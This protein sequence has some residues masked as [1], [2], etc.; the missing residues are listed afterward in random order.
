MNP[1]KETAIQLRNK[2]YSY[3]MIRQQLGISKSTLSDWLRAIPFTP[4]D[5]VLKR[6]G[7]ARLKSA[8]YNH[9][10]KFENILRMK[11]EAKHDVGEVSARDLFMLGI[12]LYLGEGSKSQEQIRIVNSDPLILK[13]A[14][15]WLREFLGLRTEHLRVAVHGYPDHNINEIVDFWAAELNL[16]VEQF[17]KTQIDT[18]QNKSALKRRKLP[19]GTAHLYVRGGGTLPLG[20]K[21]LHRKI[22]GWI[23]TVMQRIDAGVV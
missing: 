4:N 8:I 22:I 5:E 6:V 13:L 2:G 15:R 21:N 16:P 9:R 19:Y 14:S 18:R 3:G 17:I 1:Y 11:A 12:G 20:V 10:L 7:E 23:E